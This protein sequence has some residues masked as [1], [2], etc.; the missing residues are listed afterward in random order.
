M[1]NLCMLN[2]YFCNQCIKFSLSENVSLY[3]L[4][5][6]L[7]TTLNGKQKQP[8]RLTTCKSECT[9]AKGIARRCQVGLP[10]VHVPYTMKS[11]GEAH[12]PMA[13]MISSETI[14]RACYACTTVQ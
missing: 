11:V 10:L 8:L 1:P 5:L 6:T 3:Y 7:L 14:L 4:L 9:F 12:F 13:T 2:L